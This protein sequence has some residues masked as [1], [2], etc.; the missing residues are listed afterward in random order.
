MKDLINK[1]TVVDVRSPQEFAGEH[2]P[3]AI[4]I[5]L[6]QVPQKVN[7]FRRMDEFKKTNTIIMKTILQ[8]WNF[9]RML[10][11]VL[12]IAILVQGIVAR[13]TI[14]IILGLVFGGM[15]VVNVGCCGAGGC[16]INTRSANNKTEDIQ[17]E[18]VVSNK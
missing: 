3:G 1:G 5:P 14:T 2:F 15:A 7:E 6:D 9:M 18:E 12:G 17:Y 10:R 16:A 8:G 13:D 4:D 11:L